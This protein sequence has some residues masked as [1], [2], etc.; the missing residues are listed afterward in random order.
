MVAVEHMGVGVR[1]R[2][3]LVLR[4]AAPPTPVRAGRLGAERVLEAQVEVQRALAKG[5]DE[6]G[7]ADFGGYVLEKAAFPRRSGR[8]GRRRERA[9]PCN[10]QNRQRRRRLRP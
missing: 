6:D 7:P 10:G 4:L 2:L 1:L 5:G 9:R 3:R 8:A